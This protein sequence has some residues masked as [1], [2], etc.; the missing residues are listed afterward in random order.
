MGLLLARGRLAFVTLPILL[1][2]GV[3]SVEGGEP[4]AGEN[5]LAGEKELEGDPT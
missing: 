2:L 3:A 5:W 1:V 4:E